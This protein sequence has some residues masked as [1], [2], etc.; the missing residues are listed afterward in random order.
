MKRHFHLI[1]LPLLALLAL[2]AS[3]LRVG[4]NGIVAAK[5][6]APPAVPC[7]FVEIDQAKYGEKPFQNPPEIRSTQGH[8]QTTLAVKYTDPKT[9]SIGG[10]G[11]T[12][13]SYNGQ[14]VGPTLRV[15]PGDVL[16]ILLDN[17]LPVESPDE[18]AAQ[19]KQES[20]SAFIN[21]MPHSFN[22]TNL[23]T[24]GLHVSPVGNSDNV[25]LAI[26]PQ[27]SL[28]Y[29]IKLPLNHPSGSFW[30]HAHAHGSTA[31]QV[32]SGMEGA[33][34]IEDDPAKIPPAL[35]E[36]NKHEKVMVFQTT[37]YDAQ[38]KSQDI[39][40]FFPDSPPPAPPSKACQN[41]LPSCTWNG[42][43]RRTTI[44]GQIVPVI[45]MQ[46]GEVQRWR[47]IDAAFRESIFVRLRKKGGDAEGIPLHEI[48]LDGIYLGKMDTWT[49]NQ[50]IDLEPGY[51][52]DVL[53]H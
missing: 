29:E 12:L 41:Q 6:P 50:P 36:A 3:S 18:A 5:E 14:L 23:H 26:P 15:K 39:T 30:Y 48:A 4:H 42:S 35:R 51:R 22:T 53:V 52:S 1:A 7:P 28:P 20:S 38:G 33:L 8:L 21:T 2:A 44:N 13:R 25:L 10:C 19:I 49:P 47:M 17:E 9:T 11:V 16:N 31:I 43:K 45:K 46:P 40:S 24:H 27:S 32:G 34:I 37:L